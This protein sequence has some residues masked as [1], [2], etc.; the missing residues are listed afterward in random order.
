MNLS[1]D[2][3][4][5]LREGLD[6]SIA[7]KE[8]EMVA[9]AEKTEEDYKLTFNMNQFRKVPLTLEQMKEQDVRKIQDEIDEIRKLRETLNSNQNHILIVSSDIKLALTTTN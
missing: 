4:R 7:I 3:R 5:R 2:N 6:W 8:N 1:E 9:I